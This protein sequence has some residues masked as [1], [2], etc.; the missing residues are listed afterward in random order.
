LQIAIDIALVRLPLFHNSDIDNLQNDSWAHNLCF[1]CRQTQPQFDALHPLLGDWIPTKLMN[2]CHH[3]VVVVLV[4]VFV[5]KKLVDDVG[6][7][8]EMYSS[9]ND[10]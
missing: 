7:F 8:F 9:L 3:G 1:D 10:Y 5:G 6:D 2:Q 4:A